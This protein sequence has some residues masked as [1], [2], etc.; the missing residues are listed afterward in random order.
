[1]KL[2][3]PFKT[4]L[5][6]EFSYRGIFSNQSSINS[7]MPTT[8]VSLSR[9]FL[10]NN[11]LELKFSMYDIFNGGKLYEYEIN[12]TNSFRIATENNLHHAII[13]FS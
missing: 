9:Y 8:N 12:P 2:K 6:V 11:K 13:N 4:N 7:D 1:M 10:K 5:Q 3:L